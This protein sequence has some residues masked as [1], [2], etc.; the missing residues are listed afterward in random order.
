MES[1]ER[2]ALAVHGA[3]PL[4]LKTRYSKHEF[5]FSFCVP[6]GPQRGSRN[7]QKLERSFKPRSHGLTSRA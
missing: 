5:P 2:P 4:R 7:A 3:L 1:S 6:R